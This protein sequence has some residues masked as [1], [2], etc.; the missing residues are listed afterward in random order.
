MSTPSGEPNRY[1][2]V[3]AVFAAITFFALVVCAFGF[4]SLF[5]NLEVIDE[6]DAGPLVG[7][8]MV[9]FALATV[10]IS[11]LRRAAT[12]RARP[13]PGA[14]PPSTPDAQSF[15]APPSSSAASD[16]RHFG[17]P[18][19]SSRTPVAR[20]SDA[21]HFGVPLSSSPAPDTRPSDAPPSSPSNPSP[22]VPRPPA[23]DP[24]RVPVGWAVL[25]G[26]ATY[27]VYALSGAVLY[28]ATTGSIL[29]G[30]IF[31]RDTFLGPFALAVAVAAFVVALVFAI[32]VIVGGEHPRRPLWPWERD[33]G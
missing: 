5:T 19:S 32:L 33:R 23:S 29:A 11:L 3:L 9:A 25:T 20:S 15:D 8:S 30:V 27:L 14:Q 6:P 17:A 22:A 21:R 26:L 4:I 18:P 12:L 10:L 31:A 16:A 7:P 24:S 28:A 1:P 13:T 2:I